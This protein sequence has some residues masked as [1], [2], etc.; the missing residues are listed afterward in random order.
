MNSRDKNQGTANLGRKGRLVEPVIILC[1]IALIAVGIG[2]RFSWIAWNKGTNLH[3]D[4]YGL[5]N[6]LTQLSL[7][8]NLSD[9]FNTRI[10]PLS[11]YQKYDLSGKVTGDGPDNRMRWGQW[12][13]IIIRAAGELTGQTGYDEIRLLGRGL[14]A[15]AD[16][17]AVLLI[18]LIGRRLFNLKIGL[19]GAA[20]SAL[21]V[22]QIQQSHFM[23]VDNFAVLFATLAMYA[24]V[25]IA[26]RPCAVRTA[27]LAGDQAADGPYRVDRGSWK[28]FLLFGAAFGMTIACKINLLPLAGMLLIAVFT[29]IADLK[30]KSMRE[31]TTIF[32][33]AAALLFFALIA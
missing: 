31:L 9:Y 29:S 32:L 14:S 3:P 22:M 2:Y 23:T 33:L 16:S 10:S 15:L 18:F 28:W 13:M 24:C 7:P 8:K 27:P 12:P 25:R 1:L 21:A 6:T 11:P 19:L 26:Q 5:T 20:L 4:E 17:L 30:L